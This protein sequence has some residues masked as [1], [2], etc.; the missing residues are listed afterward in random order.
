MVDPSRQLVDVQKQRHLYPPGQRHGRCRTSRKRSR[1][2]GGWT[3]AGRWDL[4]PGREPPR[5]RVCRGRRH[6]CRA[7]GPVG[8]AAPSGLPA[9]PQ[10]AGLSGRS[11][12]RVATTPHGAGCESLAAH[13]KGR[14]ARAGSLP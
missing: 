13:A 9:D 6:R 4:H 5:Q 7:W 8:Q 11:G 10:D 1:A 12:G 14:P 2:A 3:L